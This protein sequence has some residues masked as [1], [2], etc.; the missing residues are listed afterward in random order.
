M[1]FTGYKL[2]VPSFGDKAGWH[3]LSGLSAV[4]SAD[5]LLS[6]IAAT[7][8]L[9]LAISVIGLFFTGEKPA[10]FLIGYALIFVLALGAQLLSAFVP[11]K[12]LGLEA[13]LFSLVI[14][15]LI[16]NIGLII[17]HISCISV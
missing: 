10:K 5:S 9:F 8:L 6:S 14:G 1:I 12:N 4:L 7:F 15:L 17:I 16:G 3:D 11:F 13:V 2:K